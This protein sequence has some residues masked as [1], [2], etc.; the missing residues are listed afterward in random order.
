M[1]EKTQEVVYYYARKVQ[2]LVQYLEKGTEKELLPEE[3]IKGHEGEK[4]KAEEKKIEGYK[5]V[6]EERPENVEGI[7]KEEI[8]VKTTP[9][10]KVRI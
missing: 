5:V 10:Y 2:V 3:I 4:Y 7:M 9:P 1:T 6:E 8:I